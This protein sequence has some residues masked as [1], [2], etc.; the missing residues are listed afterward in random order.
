HDALVARALVLAVA[1]VDA[2]GDVERLR[3]QEVGVL[4]GLPVEALLLVADVAHRPADQRFE[5]VHDLPGE[6]LVLLRRAA[7]A[8]GPHLAGQDDAVGRDKGFTGAPRF[9]V[10]GEKDVDHRVGDAVGDLVGVAFG[11]ALAG[12]DVGRPDHAGLSAS[13][14]GRRTI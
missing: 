13:G 2:A 3:M 1:G 5:R 6:G 8:P 4:G 7:L 9:G 12:E 10:L 14:G 11:N